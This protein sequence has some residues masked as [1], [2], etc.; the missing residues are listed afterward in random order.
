MK[1]LIENTYFKSIPGNTELLMSLDERFITYD[2]KPFKIEK[3][4]N[5]FVNINMFGTV[6]K[7]SI[8]WLKLISYFEVNLPEEFSK[9]TFQINFEDY[10]NQLTRNLTN[11]I[12]V[13]TKPIL[14]ENKYRIIP[15][16]TDYAISKDAE[17][18]DV[19]HRRI[20]P[21]FN[22][23]SFNYP[24]VFIYCPEKNSYKHIKVHRLVALAWVKNIDY[25]RN[26]IVNHKDANKQ[27]N[28]F[29]NLEW[30]SMSQNSK[31]AYTLGSYSFN[32][33]CKVKNHLTGE[34]TYYVSLI[35][36]S[37]FIGLKHYLNS[38]TLKENNK[39]RLLNRYFEVKEM[40]DNEPNWYYD[41]LKNTSSDEAFSLLI[42]EGKNIIGNFHSLAKIKSFFNI[43]KENLN[44]FQV[45]EL[46]ETSNPSYVIHYIDN[47]FFDPIECKDLLTG[48]IHCTLTWVELASK[49]NLKY[50]LARY[51]KFVK[52]FRQIKYK[53]WLIR[54]KS[55]EPWDVNAKE[56]GVVGNKITAT[57]SITGEVIEFDSL[58]NAVDYF[59]VD[60]KTILRRLNNVEKKY[61]GWYFQGETNN[62]FAKIKKPLS[63]GQIYPLIDGK[64]FIASC[65][66][67]S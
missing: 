49:L 40:A 13:F 42:K 59:N 55:D 5:G 17:L 65:T 36:A 7:L 44:V 4:K 30:C 24:E 6:R 25:S 48:E 21:R 38:K 11:S 57:N 46:I 18:I 9:L 14:I 47:S 41:K 31:H 61:N 35:D 28:H 50:D 23:G 45:M 1:C 64:P 29:S 62:Q 3:T 60:I 63:K 34:I 2:F 52:T 56:I 8:S 26:P 51:N 10:K 22:R 53:Q 12:M 32:K 20:I 58:T 16:F 54:Y 19:H 43:E 67:S 39:P 37:K 66:N 27:N 33:P 15:N